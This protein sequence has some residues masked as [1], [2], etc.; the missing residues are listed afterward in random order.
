M[1]ADGWRTVDRRRDRLLAISHELRR[2]QSDKICLYCLVRS[3]QHARACHHTLCDPCALLCGRPTP[4]AGIPIHGLEPPQLAWQWYPGHRRSVPRHLSN[5]PRWSPGG[6]P[7]EYL[8]LI[9][10]LFGPECT[11]QDPVD[12]SVGSSSDG[13]FQIFYLRIRSPSRC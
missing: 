8:L 3:A 12:L 13:L 5:E 4:D 1:V 6:I 11:I 7:F 10:D 2:V 9:Q